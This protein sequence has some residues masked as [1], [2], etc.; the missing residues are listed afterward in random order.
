[1]PTREVRPDMSQ[2]TSIRESGVVTFTKTVFLSGG[3][4]EVS[5][6]RLSQLRGSPSSVSGVNLG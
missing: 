3:I 4:L 5:Q 1:V 6:L 2:V